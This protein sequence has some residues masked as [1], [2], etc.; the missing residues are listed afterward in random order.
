MIV[1]MVISVELDACPFVPTLK[2][3]LFISGIQ[4]TPGK[5]ESQNRLSYQTFS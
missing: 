5:I 3:F 4:I 1:E 2:I